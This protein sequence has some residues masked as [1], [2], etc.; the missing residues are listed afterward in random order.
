M[1]VLANLI[2]VA[3]ITRFSILVNPL[4]A[5][6]FTDFGLIIRE[7]SVTQGSMGHGAPRYPPWGPGL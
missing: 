1:D 5:R 6:I 7:Q 3:I 2:T 4:R